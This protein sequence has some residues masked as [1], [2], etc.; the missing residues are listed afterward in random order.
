MT[1]HFSKIAQPKVQIVTLV[2]V[3][4][5]LATLMAGQ[6]G[7]A[8]MAQADPVATPDPESTPVIYQPPADE[9]DP[10]PEPDLAPPSEENPV[11]EEEPPA[12][13]EL[14]PQE[15]PLGDNE[16]LTKPGILENVLQS[17]GGTT[18]GVCMVERYNTTKPASVE[19]LNC[20]SNDV[21]LAIYELIDGPTSCIEGEEIQVKLRGQFVVYPQLSVGMS[22]CSYT[23]LAA[24]QTLCLAQLEILVIAITFIRYQLTT[25][26]LI[27]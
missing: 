13:D 2:L 17:N 12:E 9:K 1:K 14:P 3:L 27:L 10:E 26:T 16:V 5:V 21:Q 18:G 25:R 24:P 23:K 15:D 8:Q 20:T 4:L 19:S 6:A 11:A 22:A 7:A